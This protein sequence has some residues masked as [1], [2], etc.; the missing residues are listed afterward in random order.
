M[1]TSKRITGEERFDV[2]LGSK[3]NFLPLPPESSLYAA[4]EPGAYFCLIGLMVLSKVGRRRLIMASVTDA[5]K[6]FATRSPKYKTQGLI[7]Q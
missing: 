2:C 3:E 7:L 4:V 1:T 5:F 6:S